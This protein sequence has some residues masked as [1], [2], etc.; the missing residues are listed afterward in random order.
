MH[1]LG[2]ACMLSF[3]Y[4]NAPEV[5]KGLIDQHLRHRESVKYNVYTVNNTQICI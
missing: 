3:I 4:Y 1:F 2:E 5:K